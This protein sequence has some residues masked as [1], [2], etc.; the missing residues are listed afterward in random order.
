MI[1]TSEAARGILALLHDRPVAGAAETEDRLVRN[2]FIV[3]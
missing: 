3:V 2:D 1:P